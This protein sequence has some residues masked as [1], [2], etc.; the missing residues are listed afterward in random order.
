MWYTKMSGK[1][2]QHVRI[3]YQYI[4]EE[5]KVYECFHTSYLKVCMEVSVCEQGLRQLSQESLE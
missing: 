3:K 1:Q 4:K 5:Q 2:W